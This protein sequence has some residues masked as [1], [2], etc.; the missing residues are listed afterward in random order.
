LA[1][2]LEMSEHRTSA[3]AER[4]GTWFIEMRDKNILSRTKHMSRR[5]RERGLVLTSGHEIITNTPLG[6]SRCNRYR[7]HISVDA[8]D[9]CIQS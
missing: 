6:T 3:A 1:T 5:T 9:D 7:C 2:G 8:A 4:K